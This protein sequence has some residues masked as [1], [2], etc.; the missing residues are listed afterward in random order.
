[1]LKKIILLFII[2]C[3]V[4]GCD[5][6]EKDERIQIVCTAFPQYDWASELTK[7]AEDMFS[8]TLLTDNGTDIHSFQPSAD[9]IIS[10]SSCDMLIYTG[11]ESE[12]WV[13]DAAKNSDA[14]IINMLSYVDSEDIHDHAPDEHTWLSLRDSAVICNEISNSL[15]EL[16]PEKKDLFQSNATRY[17]QSLERLDKEYQLAVDEAKNKILVFA[18]RFPFS[19]MTG[20]YDLTCYAAFPGCSAESEA[21]FETVA[22][23][24]SAIDENNLDYVFVTDNSGL[25]LA[26]TVIENTLKKNQQILSLN[27]MQTVTEADLKSGLSYLDIMEENLETL[28]IALN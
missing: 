6:T 11:G 8:I 19:P 5:N 4:S 25:D 17:S 20:D 13:A 15:K 10:I 9:D 27:S 3:S 21:S 2:L 22:N 26:K 24:A 12:K 28:K 16:L 7:G 1:M 23:L 18:D 14:K